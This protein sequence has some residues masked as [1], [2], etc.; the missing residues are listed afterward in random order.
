M[1]LFQ[2][3]KL[4]SETVLGGFSAEDSLKKRNMGRTGFWV[5]IFALFYGMSAYG[6]AP[7][8]IQKIAMIAGDETS[9]IQELPEHFFEQLDGILLEQ[10]GP[11]KNKTLRD[12]LSRSLK[13]PSTRKLYETARNWANENG[14]TLGHELLRLQNIQLNFSED[15]LG[16]I[17]KKGPVVVTMNHGSGIAETLAMVEILKKIRPDV[18]ILTTT[19]MRGVPELAEDCIF[20]DN[21]A[22]TKAD[23][24]ANIKA[25]KVPTDYLKEQ[26]GLIIVAP[27]GAVS[28]FQFSKARIEDPIW[29][30]T[31]AKLIK[32]SGASVVPIYSDLV[33]SLGFQIL[34][35]VPIVKSMLILREFLNKKN[36]ILSFEIGEV[37]PPNRFKDWENRR[38]I[39]DF[40]R[41]HTYAL[42][43]VRK[44]RE[45]GVEAKLKTTSSQKSFSPPR[46]KVSEDLLESGLSLPTTQILYETPELKAVLVYGDEMPGLLD[47]LGRLRKI[48]FAAAGEGVDG[49]QDNDE[50]DKYYY[51]IFIWSKDKKN[52]SS[53]RSPIQGA[54]RIGK[55]DEILEQRGIDGL[56]SSKFLK[57]HPDLVKDLQV[58]KSTLELGRAFVMEEFQ[59]KTLWPLWRAIGQFIVQNPK[60]EN[61]MGLVSMSNEYNP[62]SQQLAVEFLR[63]EFMDQ[64]LAKY[65]KARTSPKFP[66]L[67]LSISDLLKNEN[68]VLDDVDDIVQRIDGK[69]LP[70]LLQFYTK[71]LGAKV[72]GV[73]EDKA[74]KVLD[75]GI[76]TRIPQTRAAIVQRAFGSKAF[77]ELN[78][79][80]DAKYGP[81]GEDGKRK[82]SSFN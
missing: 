63:G 24:N 31:T 15:Q 82:N 38:E 11:F 6:K 33:N 53:V 56:Y 26:G 48:R 74:F 43:A 7:D 34:G 62:L 28:Y 3:L 4:R 39:V 67:D 55:V 81:R 76:M 60:Y 59:G 45:R 58:K 5:G 16:T 40:L 72:I 1:G 52:W 57:I 25:M 65:F 51:H 70:E 78:A 54:Y 17:P 44:A 18:K 68:L 10:L 8:C 46:E 35:Q 21:N 2:L 32:E 73:S 13:I 41:V 71:Y 27:A 69:P 29:H 61:L 79:L 30:A 75:V 80:W 14:T 64:E 49:P 12:L 37:F 9:G 77:K 42:A 36:R 66:S 47:E 22:K 50:Y 19:M 23:R 20:I